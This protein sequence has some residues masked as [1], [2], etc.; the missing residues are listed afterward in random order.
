MKKILF[1]SMM[2][3]GAMS[4]NAQFTV[5]QPVEVPQTSS[6][7]SYGYG[8]PFTIYEHTYSS[9]Y[10]QQQQAKPKMQEV[11]LK[12]YYKKG[13]DWYSLPIRVGV[14]GDEVRLLSIKIQ[15]VWSNC[16]SKASAVGGFDSEEIR[17]NFN[18]KAFTSIYGT[19]YF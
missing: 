11:T 7:P 13:N 16:G 17:D 1:T 12:G 15:N 8:T 5:Y 10:R 2:L 4:A 18:Y 3:L 19:I 14:I 6:V 9:P